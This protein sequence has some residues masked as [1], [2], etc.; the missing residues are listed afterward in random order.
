MPFLCFWIFFL[1]LFRPLSTLQN[2]ERYSYRL[3]KVIFRTLRLYIVSHC[4]PPA[5]SGFF[6][7]YIQRFTY[8]NASL[9]TL[10]F[11]VAI[12]I[13]QMCLAY[14]KS[15]SRSLQ[16]RSLDVGRA[17]ENVSLVQ[18]SLKDC[19]AN[20]EQFNRKCYERSIKICEPGK[21]SR[22][23]EKASCLSTHLVLHNCLSLV[24]DVSSLTVSAISFS[25]TV[26]FFG[27]YS[28]NFTT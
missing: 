28:K 17:L 16:K 1:L 11:V 9:I 27:E 7:L 6:N 10:E 14:M 18:S 13:V 21:K 25:C 2:C 20:V 15:L 4:L 19:R 3:S 24:L 22:N 12:V 8:L 23:T 26:S 5:G